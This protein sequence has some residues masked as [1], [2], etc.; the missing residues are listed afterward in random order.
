MMLVAFRLQTRLRESRD[1][2]LKSRLARHASTS[3]D[4]RLGTQPLPLDRLGSYLLKPISSPI[5]R[6]NEPR[7]RPSRRRQPY[8]DRHV[9]TKLKNWLVWFIQ[10]I[11]LLSLACGCVYVFPHEY[12]ESY[13]DVEQLNSLFGFNIVLVMAVLCLFANYKIVFP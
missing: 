11:A 1:E 2:M 10:L 8:S 5:D 4:Q 13:L 9:F 12:V 3:T 7:L 6:H